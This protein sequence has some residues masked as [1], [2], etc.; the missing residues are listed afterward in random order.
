MW[1]KELTSDA[2]YCGSNSTL[3]VACMSPRMWMSFER[4][5]FKSPLLFFSANVASSLLSL[6]NI[7][8]FSN[9]CAALAVVQVLHQT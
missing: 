6:G 7:F 3:S 8:R 1:F 5:Q 9:V 2:L 4:L